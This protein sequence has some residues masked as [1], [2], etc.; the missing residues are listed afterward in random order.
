MLSI[1]IYLYIQ[2]FKILDIFI[3]VLRI[4]KLDLIR[5]DSAKQRMRI[6]FIFG[7]LIKITYNGI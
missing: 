2:M 1:R 4:L 6:D 5:S 3:Y 7:L